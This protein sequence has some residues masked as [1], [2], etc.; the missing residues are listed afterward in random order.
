VNWLVRLFP[1]KGWWLNLPIA[2]K[3]VAPIW[4]LGAVL[5][6]LFIVFMTGGARDQVLISAEERARTISLEMREVRAYYTRNV[7]GK[8]EGSGITVSVSYADGRASIPVPD[9]MV[10]ELND[11]FWRSQGIQLH[12]YS[13]HPFPYR[14]DGGV[15]DGFQRDA[16][17]AVQDDPDQEVIRVESMRPL[18][19]G[20]EGTG[21]RESV[22]VLR[23]ATADVMV[24]QAC[25][26]CHNTEARSPKRDWRLG[27]VAGV[28]EVVVPVEEQLDAV[29]TNVWVKGG[30]IGTVF[31]LSVLALAS[32]IGHS[33]SHPIRRF[34]AAAGQVAAGD[35]TR[36]LRVI[37]SDEIGSMRNAL[38]SV[39]EAMSRSI[40]TFAESSLSVA[41]SSEELAQVSQQLNASAEQTSEQASVVSAA[42]GEVSR[43]VQAVATAT[44]EM[45]A[46]IREIARNAHDASQVATSAV[47]MAGQTNETVSK[48]GQSS[49]EIG[50]VVEV[51]SSIAGQTNLLALNATIEAARAGDAGKGFAVVAKEVK[52]LAR[53][54]AIATD[55]ISHRVAA[56]Q[57][58][59]AGAVRVIADI[60]SVVGRIHEIQNTIAGAVE[61]QNATTAEIGRMVSEAARGSAEIAESIASVAE[62]AQNNV[63][64]AEATRGAAHA[65]A[66]MA[67]ELQRLVAQ[68]KY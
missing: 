27:D 59:S 42:A 2:W 10:H 11:I 24:E 32:T 61:E 52:E 54:T 9:T 37:S 57:Q 6:V 45:S 29:M 13:D 67:A 19:A 16:L 43:N 5:G 41:S 53:Q 56:I 60:S 20:A 30:I 31:V 26:S 18:D 51:I 33:I 8:V 21:S 46:S 34:V 17:L 55:E 14:E 63:A 44:E 66:G 1:Y 4:T 64:G 15:R 23:Y 50:R 39:A 22:R 25:V 40:G 3:M 58:D 36:R 35:L 38:N 62:A 48:L 7:V 68:F 65:L 49:V 28:F 12:L 47:E